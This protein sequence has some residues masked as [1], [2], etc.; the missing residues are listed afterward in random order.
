MDKTYEPNNFEDRIY[1]TWIKNGCFNTEV[2]PNKKPFVIMMPP[3]NITGQLH[4]GHAL[5]LSIQDAVI[6]YKRMKGFEALYMPGTDHASIATEM[7]IVEALKQ[8]GVTKQG[9]GREEFLRRAFLWNDKYGGRI[10]EQQRRLGLS[11]DWRR[12]AFTMDDNRSRAVEAVFVRLYKEGL[13]YRGEKIIN[14]CPKCKTA[15]SDAEVEFKEKPSHLWH[16]KYPLAG[17]SAAADGIVVATTRPETMLGDTAVAVNPRD[18]RYKHLIGKK[19]VLPLVGRE[20]PIIAD[21]YVEA[22]FGSGA[23]KI[24]P[25]HDPN[26]F[27]IGL[28]HNLESVQ[29]I[30]DDGVMNNNAGAYTGLDRAEARKKIVADLQGCGA[31]TRTE[32]YTHNVGH[33]YRCD[34]IIEP[35]IKKQWFLKMNDLALPAVDAVKSGEIKFVPK[36]FEKMYL[37]WMENTRDWCISRQL[38][39]GHRIPV[40][41][42]D[43]CGAEKVFEGTDKAEQA[44]ACNYGFKSK[45]ACGGKL[46]QDEDV[47]DTWFSS[48]LW[49]F[50]TLDWPSDSADLDYFYPGDVLVTAYDIIGFWVSRMIFSGLKHTGQK[51]FDT[52]LI[53]GLVRDSEGKKMSKSSGN[54]VDPIEAM[55]KFG[56]DA[57]RISLCAGVAMG[58]DTKYS[59]EKLETFRNFLNKLWN[60]SRFVVSNA[61]A[62][63][64]SGELP[65]KLGLADKWILGRLNA[66]VAEVTKLMDRFE[67]GLAATALYEFVWNEFCD[68]YIEASK[69]SLYS[70]D[71]KKRG[72]TVEVLGYVLCNILKLVHPLAP[73]IT[74]E[75]YSNLPVG[76]GAAA[77]STAGQNDIMMSEYPVAGKSSKKAVKD[78]EEVIEL[79]KGIR[80]LRRELNVSQTKRTAI[81]IMPVSGCEAKV[82]AAAEYIQKLALGNQ[83]EVISAKPDGKFATFVGGIAEVFIPMGDLVD[84]SAEKVR[85]E[86]ELESLNNEI[87]RAEK[88]L[89][90]PGFTGR[91]PAN[92][93]AAEREKLVKF[94]DQKVRLLAGLERLR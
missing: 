38:W 31:L 79:I 85:L 92:V 89:N 41:H 4:I 47:L 36:R 84:F 16:I 87:E 73:F 51:P 67:I 2:N 11:C 49:P 82:K 72:G 28:R 61:G 94:K 78:F 83:L 63:G 81:Y 13:I 29:V 50:A 14:W 12:L 75:I 71:L 65:K 7:K 56:A 57:L 80:N 45:C 46:R 8:E 52:V 40:W 1:K 48:A 77:E 19:L 64:F 60:A 70:D 39:W 74:A 25:A 76:T 32:D 20:I 93:V 27:E 24:T 53:H 44:G 91:A 69:I 35:A 42:C 68:W 37:H 59:A 62:E 30:G 10:V 34:D 43:G 6:R 23:V 5:D 88:M 18:K 26:D 90:N 54:G 86:K 55:D 21:D 58:G 66:V 17:S 33:C 22:E 3:P 9:L 15:I